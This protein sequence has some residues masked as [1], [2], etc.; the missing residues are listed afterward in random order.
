MSISSQNINDLWHGKSSPD[1]IYNS[2]LKHK[3]QYKDCKDY[4]IATSQSTV[5]HP[6]ILRPVTVFQLFHRNWENGVGGHHFH[7]IP[8]RIHQ[9]SR[10][11]LPV[12]GK[13]AERAGKRGLRLPTVDQLPGTCCGFCGTRN[14]FMAHDLCLCCNLIL[15]SDLSVRLAFTSEA[16]T[17]TWRPSI[18]LHWNP[19]YW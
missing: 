18:I 11:E 5:A 2:D 10:H 9:P 8:S 12:W 16:H 4:S 1:Q 14:Y 17:Q 3:A 7:Q 13:G 19:E 15:E 6:G